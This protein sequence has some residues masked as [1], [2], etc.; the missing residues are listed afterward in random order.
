[1]S[2]SSFLHYLNGLNHRDQ[3]FYILMK[4]Y[5]EY[6]YKYP[7]MNSSTTLSNIFEPLLSDINNMSLTDNNLSSNNKLSDTISYDNKFTLNKYKDK[8]HNYD[9]DELFD[10]EFG[11]WNSGSE[12][13]DID[14]KD[15][16]NK[17]I[18]NKNTD[19]KVIDNKHS[20]NSDN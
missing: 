11:P 20:D 3:L 16:D 2:T 1:M 10:K 6:S 4:Q 8:N 5:E 18:N 15:T 13:E 17:V 9:F 7:Y 14:N 19:N 12:N